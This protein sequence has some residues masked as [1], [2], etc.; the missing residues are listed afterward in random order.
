ME[1]VGFYEAVGIEADDGAM[2]GA[3]PFQAADGFVHADLAGEAYPG[4]FAG[5]VE[6]LQDMEAQVVGGMLLG[7]VSG[8][9]GLGSVFLLDGG[10]MVGAAV[11][12]DKDFDG[13]LGRVT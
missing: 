12:D 6:V 13:M 4:V 5:E 3:C 2:G 9:M 11:D 1:V 7:P 8:S 10:F